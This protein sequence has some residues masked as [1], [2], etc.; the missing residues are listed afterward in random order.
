MN[1]KVFITGASSGIG[2]YIAYE[3]AKRGATIGL[4]A[5][6][7]NILEKVANKCKELSGNPLF[8]QFD[9]S[10]PVA[11]KQAIDDFIKKNNGIDIVIANAGISGK[12]D[13][14]SGVP[15]EVNRMLSTNIL[16]VSNTVLPVI[17]SMLK[18]KSGKIV[19]VSSI[20]GFRALPSRSSYSASKVAIRFMNNSWRYTFQNQGLNFITICP[21]FIETSLTNKNKFKMPFLMN[22]DVFAQKMI[23]AIDK[24]KKTYVAPW[25]WKFIIPMIKIVPDWLI[26]LVASKMYRKNN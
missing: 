26:N 2:E 14:E 12:V 19:V 3:Y 1:I 7:K 22:V 16:G 11:T 20:A 4:G 25:Q 18:Q 9:V 5:R 21:G 24:N 17:P 15:D 10:D 6:R 13:L 23:K 8:Y